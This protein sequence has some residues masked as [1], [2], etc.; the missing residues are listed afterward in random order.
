MVS[1]QIRNVPEHVH[2]TLVHRAEVAGQSLQQYLNGEL[3]RLAARPSNRDL[4]Q[5]IEA[6]P[7]PK[8]TVDEIL[9]ALDEG[10]AGR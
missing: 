8:I 9:E 3:A 5:R 2:A 10:R 4:M 6:R 7:K 1:I